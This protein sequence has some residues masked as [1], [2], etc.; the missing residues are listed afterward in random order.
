[1]IIDHDNVSVQYRS[2]FTETCAH[3]VRIGNLTLSF[4][5]TDRGRELGENIIKA[6][7]EQDIAIDAARQETEDE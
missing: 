6:C 1:M 5:D 3:R 2:E 4:T 7:D